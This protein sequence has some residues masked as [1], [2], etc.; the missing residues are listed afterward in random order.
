MKFDV[1]KVPFKPDFIWASPPCESFSVASIGHHWNVDNTPKTQEA[2]DGMARVEKT[3][4][5]IEQLQATYCASCFLCRVSPVTPLL[6]VNM[7]TLG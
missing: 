3:I 1:S 6:T 2:V 7:A 4:E 5:L